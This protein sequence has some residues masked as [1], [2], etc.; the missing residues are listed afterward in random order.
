MLHTPFQPC[1]GQLQGLLRIVVCR[2]SRAA[3]VKGH[4]DVRSDYTL[5]IHV[6]LRSEDMLR[7]VDMRTE[8]AS[9]RSQLPYRTEGEDLES[10]AVGEDRPVP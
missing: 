5:G 1:L 10:A 2:I 9:F 8:Y 4:D 7:S 3:L 6:V